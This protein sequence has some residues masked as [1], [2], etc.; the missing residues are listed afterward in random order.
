MNR[1]ILKNKNKRLCWLIR[2]H[3]QIFIVIRLGF[4]FQAS[5]IAVL[6]VVKISLNIANVFGM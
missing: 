1:E 2:Q 6:K 5:A 4:Y 3:R